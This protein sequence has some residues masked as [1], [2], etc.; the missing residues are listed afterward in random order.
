MIDAWFIMLQ[1][2]GVVMVIGTCYDYHVY[3]ATAKAT[4]KGYQNVALA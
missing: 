4:D 2:E 3:V 1:N